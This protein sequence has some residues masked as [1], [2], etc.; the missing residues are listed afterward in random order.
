MNATLLKRLARQAGVI[1]NGRYR[2]GDHFPVSLPELERFASLVATHC[3]DVAAT[4]IRVQVARTT[5][6]PKFKLEKL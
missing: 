1:K 3:E 5:L 2:L 4:A 6:Q